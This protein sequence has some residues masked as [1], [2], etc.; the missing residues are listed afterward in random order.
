MTTAE[1]CH[2]NR[3][4]GPEVIRALDRVAQPDGRARLAMAVTFAA[5][6]VMVADRRAAVIIANLW[7][8]GWIPAS[9]SMRYLGHG[10]G[11]EFC[12]SMENCGAA[13][14]K[15]RPRPSS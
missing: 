5:S 11:S 13:S 8:Q 1:R 4:L 3:A 12:G 9:G 6:G 14:G 7:A 10:Y 15:N 2:I